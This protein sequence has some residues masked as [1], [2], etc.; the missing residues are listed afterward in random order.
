MLNFLGAGQSVT[1]KVPVVV[2]D[3]SGNNATEDVSIL[4]DGGPL[5]VADSASVQTGGVISATAAQGVLSNDI[6]P[7]TQDTLA[8]SAVDGQSQNVGQAV[9]GTHGTLVLNAN[10]SYM[11]FETSTHVP[12][13]GVVDVFTY[14][15]ND[16]HGGISTS[17]LSISV[18]P[19][20]AVGPSYGIDYI[21]KAGSTSDPVAANASTIAQSFGFVGEYLGSDPSY[22]LTAEKANELLPH[23]QIF[24]IYEHQGMDKIAYYKGTGSNDAYQRGLTDGM[25]AYTAAM[26]DGQG[27]WAGSAIYFG[28]ECPV[29]KSNTNL[30]ADIEDYYMGV[31]QGFANDAAKES[32]GDVLF[33]VGIYGYGAADNAVKDQSGLATYSWLAGSPAA[34]EGYTNWNIRQILDESAIAAQLPS[35]PIHNPPFAYVASDETNGQYFGQWGSAITATTVKSA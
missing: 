17:R 26:S 24:S 25:A 11:Y 14:T 33:T 35:V 32:G 21:L 4:I 31:Q 18:S 16:G 28:T 2:A 6:D 30:L 19:N 20:V 10:G 13:S 15:I 8:V 34:A 12:R 9:R 3:Q 7:D 22:Y 29:A 1:L 23:L 27:Q 5:A